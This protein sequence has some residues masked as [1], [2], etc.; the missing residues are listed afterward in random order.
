[1]IKSITEQL[2][3]DLQKYESIPERIEVL[4][5]SYKG[6]TCYIVS[7]GPSLKNYEP[8]YLKS[9]LENKLVFT[10]KQSYLLLKEICDFHILNFTNFEPYQWSN[11]TIVAWE[12]FEQYHPQMILE[13]G[14]NVDVMF[15]VIRNHGTMDNTQ[16]ARLDFD[17]FTMD[18]TYDRAWGPGLMYEMAIPLAMF[19]GC[20]EIITVGWDIGDI[21]K[22][23]G[24]NQ[25]EEQWQDHFYEGKSN[26]QYAPTSMTKQEVELVTESVSFVH[27]W[28]K[29]KGIDFKICSDRNPADK[30]IPRVEL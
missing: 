29:E 13:N 27:K 25:N 11:E 30:S 3:K 9:K 7:A 21:S 17:D 14:F 1:M 8:E 5:D 23:S 28:L 4:K 12:V 22:F 2:K 19:L 6:E 18:K 26:I 16:A 24:D 15:P 20:K 10:I